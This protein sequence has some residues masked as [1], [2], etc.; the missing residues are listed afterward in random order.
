MEKIR[1]P[2]K[3][4]KELIKDR[5][6]YVQTVGKYDMPALQTVLDQNDDKG[7]VVRVFFWCK[8]E[9]ATKSIELRSNRCSGGRASSLRT[10]ASDI[11]K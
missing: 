4:K 3:L 9:Y 8:D 5:T 6:N 2:H 10:T 1:S 7:T 11:S